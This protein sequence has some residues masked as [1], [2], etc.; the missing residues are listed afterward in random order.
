VLNKEN[1]LFNAK[2]H[3]IPQNRHRMIVLA[4]LDEVC[5]KSAVHLPQRLH[6]FVKL[7]SLIDGDR[8]KA[9]TLP[10][11][12][13]PYRDRVETAYVKAKMQGYNLK[14]DAIV[15]DIAA[16]HRFKKSMVNCMPCI[17]AS[18]GSC[19]GYHV[20]TTNEKMDIPLMERVMAFPQ[21]FFNY[22]KAG[23][24]AN[25]YGH[26]LGNSIAINVLMRV[27]PPLLRAARIAAPC[28]A[29]DYWHDVI[30]DFSVNGIVETL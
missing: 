17:T 4:V 15:T 21:G 14:E 26:M 13:C 30:E 22:K 29:P 11:K 18:R 2:E 10:S 5:D 27:F 28:G 1:Q 19:R 6:G 16:S 8:Q 20:S 24:S 25:Q 12:D 23:V 3:G 7:T 9:G